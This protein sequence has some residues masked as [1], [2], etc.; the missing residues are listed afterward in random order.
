MQVAR[1]PEPSQQAWLAYRSNHFQACRFGLHGSYVTPDGQRVRLVDHLR[2]LFERLAP[3][4]EELGTGDML[5]TLRDEILRNGND[6]RWLRGQFLKVRE[7]PLV[8]ESMA[9][10]W[11]GQ[12]VQDTPVGGAAPHPRD[13][14]A[15]GRRVRPEHAAGRSAARLGRAPALTQAGG[16]S[17]P[18]VRRWR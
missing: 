11:R 13:L 8:V 6:A 3:V 18:G 4:A 10:N 9:Q 15:S 16:V 2:A 7:L 12:G 17:L 14:R 1:D 5:Q